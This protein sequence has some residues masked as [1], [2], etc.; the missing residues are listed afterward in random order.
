MRFL[1]PHWIAGKKDD[2]PFAD[3]SVHYHWPIVIRWFRLL[4]RK[5]FADPDPFAT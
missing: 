1:S 4:Q 3:W 5:K 2:M